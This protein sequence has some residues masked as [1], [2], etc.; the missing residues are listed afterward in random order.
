MLNKNKKKKKVNFY[1]I[2]TFLFGYNKVVYL[3]QF[4]LWI[5]AKVLKRVCGVLGNFYTMPQE[6]LSVCPSS[7]PSFC[8]LSVHIFV[9]G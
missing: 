8:L 5:P 2:Y 1:I 9:S 7:H 3:T 4:L 6:S